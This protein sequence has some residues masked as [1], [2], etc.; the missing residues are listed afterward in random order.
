LLREHLD[1]FASAYIDDMIIYS[2]GIR[3][4]HFRKVK[5]VLQKL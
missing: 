1:D 4:D 3:E 5:T 2:N